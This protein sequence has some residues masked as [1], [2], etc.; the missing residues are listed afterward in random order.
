M[1]GLVLVSHSA[2]LA[3]GVAAIVNQM[4]QGRVPLAAAGGTNLPEA[5]IGTDPVKV[6]AAIDAVYSEDGVLV[7]MDL[8]SAIMSAEAAVEMV[9]DA[10]RRH[11]VLCEAPLVEGAVAAAVRAMTGGSLPDVLAEARGAYAAKTAQLADLLHL[12]ASGAILAVT[13][14]AGDPYSASEEAT[15]QLAIVVPNQLGLH[16]RP[17]ARLVSLAAQYNAQMTLTVGVRS[18]TATSMNQVATLGARQGDVMVVNAS[19][20]QAEEAL[21]ALEALAV[22]NFGDPIAVSEP[23]EII[24]AAITTGSGPDE[25]GELGGLP[26]SEGIAFGPAYVYRPQQPQVQEILGAEPAAE[27]QRLTAAIAD[28]AEH[29]RQ[30]RTDVM[31]RV[32]AGEAGIFDAHLLMVQDAELLQSALQEIELRRVNAEAAWQRALQTLANRYRTLPDPYLARRAE[33]VLD[34]GQRVLRKLA[35]AA[36]DEDGPVL[37]EAAILVSH[38]LKPSDLARVDPELVLGIVTELGSTS[39][40]AAI[41]AR[42]LGLPAVTGVGPFLGQVENGQTLALDGSRGCVWLAPTAEQLQELEQTGETWAQERAAMKQSA[43]RPAVTRDGRRVLVAAN[44]NG[45]SDLTAAL[46]LGAEGVGLFRTEYLFMDRISPPTEQEQLET[47]RAV[48][49]QLKGKPLIIRTLDVGGDKPL[50]Y[51][52]SER[53]ANPFL[54]RRGLRYS[55]DRPAL[56]KSQLRAI[57]RAAAEQPTK[58][59]FPM[60]STFEELVLVDALIEEACSELQ[61]AGLPFDDDIARGIMIETPAAVMAADHL[62]RLVDFFSIGT[63]DLAQYMMAADRSNAAVANLVTPYQP[64]VIRAIRQVVEAA[65]PAGIPVSLCGELAGDARATPLLLGLG[66]SELSMSA[67]AIP[68]VKARVRNLTLSA[69]QKLAEELLTYESA[70]DIEARLSEP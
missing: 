68:L 67:P 1:I 64:A 33:D 15:L 12:P 13:A 58:I 55:L 49:R 3:Q 21:A 69:A 38:E 4:T 17:A 43:Q 16:A 30:V 31:Q 63:N 10:R 6:L 70:T 59:M 11:I 24:A 37:D 44:I 45:P 65:R 32:G 29:L 62:V 19:G 52:R 2:L 20:P 8:G 60:V 42:A 66:I 36:L 35:G 46:S 18:A 5:P 40:H 34:V 23:S 41:L 9:D 26:A 39:D 27:R 7:L 22:D 14:P 25:A 61:D 50:P 28:V 57:M 51:L 56:F 53:E 47:Y 48:A 54:G